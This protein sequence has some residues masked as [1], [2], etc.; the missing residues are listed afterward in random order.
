LTI[1]IFLT[2]GKKNSSST[3]SPSS[4]VSQGVK[5]NG[6]GEPTAET[7]ANPVTLSRRI[8]IPI[9]VLYKKKPL[10][11]PQ[12]HQSADASEIQE[13]TAD[14]LEAIGPIVSIAESFNKDESIAAVSD[15]STSSSQTC[16]PMTTRKRK[17]KSAV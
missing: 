5:R 16:A 10:K 2:T 4:P 15:Y 8:I 12:P 13:L 1:I 17:E 9:T 7:V 6:N 11:Q 14:S 3:C